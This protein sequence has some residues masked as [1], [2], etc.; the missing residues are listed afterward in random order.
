MFTATILTS[1]RIIQ[2]PLGKQRQF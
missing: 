2:L 1:V